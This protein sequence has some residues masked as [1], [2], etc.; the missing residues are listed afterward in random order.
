MCIDRW[1]F[2]QKCVYSTKVCIL[3]QVYILQN[4][5]FYQVYILQKREY[6]TKL[7]ISQKCICFLVFLV[8]LDVFSFGVRLCDRYLDRYFYKSVCILQKCIFY[9]VHILQECVYSTK[10]CILQK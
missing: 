1:V 6:S 5:I 4:Y 8:Q 7:C 3:Y 9:Q 10:L 2:L